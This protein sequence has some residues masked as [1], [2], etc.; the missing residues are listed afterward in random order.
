MKA[1]LICDLLQFVV[2]YADGIVDTRSPIWLVWHSKEDLLKGWSCRVSFA[3]EYILIQGS[4]KQLRGVLGVGSCIATFPEIWDHGN[5]GRT[6][7]LRGEFRGRIPYL[8]RVIRRPDSQLAY[9]APAPRSMRCP[10]SA[11]L[12]HNWR[13]FDINP[14]QSPTVLRWSE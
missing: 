3:P 11:R 13:T 2:M 4:L 9:L 10:F 6:F 5:R 12:P 7:I 1:Q 14:H 8:H